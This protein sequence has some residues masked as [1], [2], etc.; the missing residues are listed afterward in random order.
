LY[1]G[2][3]ENNEVG[4][5]NGREGAALIWGGGG[6]KRRRRKTAILSSAFRA[7]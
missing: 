2:I 4:D 3:V 5:C 1:G 7:N 6:E